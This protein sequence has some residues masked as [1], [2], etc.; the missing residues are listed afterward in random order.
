MSVLGR[1]MRTDLGGRIYG[2]KSKALAQLLVPFP[3][4]GSLG[5]RTALY[6]QLQRGS[7]C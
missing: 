6:A 2:P 3:T 7:N 4:R 1:A 5:T